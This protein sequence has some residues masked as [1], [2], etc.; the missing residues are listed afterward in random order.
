[1]HRIQQY[2]LKMV[3]K[4]ELATAV[5]QMPYRA[6]KLKYIG[7]ICIINMMEHTKSLLARIQT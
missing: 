6:K 4:K 2:G 3:E 7:A 5:R 1:V